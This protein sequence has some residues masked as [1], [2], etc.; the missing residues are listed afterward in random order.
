MKKAVM[1]KY[2]ILFRSGY[3]LAAE[4]RVWILAPNDIQAQQIVMDTYNVPKQWITHVSLWKKNVNV[5][6][7]GQNVWEAA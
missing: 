5:N 6:I 1:N 7:N 3:G 2:R 4:R